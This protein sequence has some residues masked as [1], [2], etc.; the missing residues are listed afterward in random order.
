MK[1]DIRSELQR[2]C[3]FIDFLYCLLYCF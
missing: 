3:Y 2:W 1:V